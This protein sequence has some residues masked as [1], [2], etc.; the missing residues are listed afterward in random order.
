MSRDLCSVAPYCIGMSYGRDNQEMNQCSID[1][2]KPFS[3]AVVEC[4]SEIDD[5]EP[6]TRP[7]LHEAIDPEALNNLFRDRNNGEV[8]FTYLDYEITVNSDTVTTTR[9]LEDQPVSAD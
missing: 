5:E 7:P 1:G 2:D 3:L 8:T 9:R 6:E 4:V